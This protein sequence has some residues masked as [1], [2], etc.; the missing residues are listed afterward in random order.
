MPDL[1]DKQYLGDSVYAEFD[2]YHI[3]LTTENGF[4]DDP[5]NRIALEPPVLAALVA[6]ANRKLA[7]PPEPTNV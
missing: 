4:P 5:T 3:W 6:Y 1:T 7:T 2:G